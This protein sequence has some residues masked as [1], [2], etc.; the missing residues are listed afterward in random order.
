MITL[1]ASTACP[2]FSTQI[3]AEFPS[4]TVMLVFTISTVQTIKESY[5]QC[6][7][8][9]C[10]LPMQEGKGSDQVAFGKH[11]LSLAPTSTYPLSQLCVT[12]EPTVVEVPMVSPLTGLPGS[13]HLFTV[14]GY[15]EFVDY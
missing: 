13:I 2:L 7:M 12:V 4:P 6:S 1:K 3:F 15:V 11:T 14:N 9:A 10:E 5:N 8:Y